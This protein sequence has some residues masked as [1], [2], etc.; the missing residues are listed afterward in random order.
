LYLMHESTK[1]LYFE[2]ITWV[3]PLTDLYIT[4]DKRDLFE[5]K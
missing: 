3:Y 1:E 4:L 5:I 2:A